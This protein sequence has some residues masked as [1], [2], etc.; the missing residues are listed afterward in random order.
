AAPR[1]SFTSL[2]AEGTRLARWGKVDKALSCFDRALQLREG[3]KHCL[4]AR[5]EC[6]LRLGDTQNALKDAEASLQGDS[7]FSQGLYQKAETLYTMGDFEFALVFYHRGH[8]LRPELQ[9]FRL[10]IEKC[11]EAIVNCTDCLSFVK[12][13]SKAKLGFVSRQAESNKSHQ[14]LQTK[15]TND[16]KRTKKEKPPRNPKAE[17]QLLGELYDD[18]IYLEKLLKDKDLMECSTKEGIKV[19]E[20]VRSGISYL[21][22]CSEFWQQQKPIYARL[23][24]RQRQQQRQ[25]HDQRLRPAELSRCVEKCLEDAEMLLA[26][27][28]AEESC[29]RAKRLLRA[30]QRYSDKELP[31]KSQLMGDLYSCIGNTQLKLGQLEA[32]LQSHRLDLETARQNHLPAAVSRALENMGRVYARAGR[33][34]DAI[35]VWEEKIPM[36]TSSLERS[37]LFHELGQCYLKLNEA[38]AARSYG[39]KSL[40]AANEEG[41]AEWQLQATALLAESQVKL[42]DYCSA[43]KTLEK[44]L[45]KSQLVNTAPMKEAFV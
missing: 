20:L 38:K 17:R 26:G 7:T 32:A 40:E 13:D 36:A 44:A 37:W 4:V 5:S 35:D 24:E 16:Q 25:L 21:D 27:D 34:Q 15:E 33:F 18:K 28:T 3:D 19:A 12:P 8:R 41:D 29:K 14:K 2:M 45:E 9:K 11:Q 42:K 31:N 23:R 22:T 43:I 10:G 30:V 39:Q 6:Y 1:G